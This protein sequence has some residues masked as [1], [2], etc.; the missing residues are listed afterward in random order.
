MSMLVEPDS[1]LGS[2]EK[3]AGDYFI[4]VNKNQCVSV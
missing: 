1:T 4:T 2:F 3:K